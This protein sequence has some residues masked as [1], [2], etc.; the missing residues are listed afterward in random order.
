MSDKRLSP[1]PA[2]GRRVSPQ[3][4]LQRVSSEQS[5]NFAEGLDFAALVLLTDCLF[6]SVA[7]W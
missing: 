1:R 2:V 5:V 4:L 6:F 3:G 7:F